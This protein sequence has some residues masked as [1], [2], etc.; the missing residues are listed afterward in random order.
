MPDLTKPKLKIIDGIVID[1]KVTVSMCPRLDHGPLTE[2]HAIVIHQT[3]GSSIDGVWSKYRNTASG[4]RTGAHFLI[5][6]DGKIYQTLAI[7]KRCA[8]VAPVKSRCLAE[9]S[10][11]AE[12]TKVYSAILGRHDLTQGA[13]NRA[14]SSIEAKKPYPSRYPW[15]PDSIGIE[16]VS[17][18]NRKTGIY[19]NP[20]LQQ[21]VSTHWVVP[22]L[23]E[24][25][26]LRE[27]DVYRHPML[28]AKNETEAQGVTW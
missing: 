23:M 6:K 22:A 15:N 2:V 16:V 20:T 7:T 8:H 25:L 5:D 17:M 18:S 28:S 9:H 21:N 11:T 1:P 19:E 14:I 10:C 13:K 12:E 24:A 3:G 4:D 27:T 26:S